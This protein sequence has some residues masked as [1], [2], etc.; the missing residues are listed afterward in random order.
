MNAINHYAAIRAAFNAFP[1]AE[2][3]E[4]RKALEAAKIIGFSESL[5]I[6]KALSVVRAFLKKL[7][8]WEREHE[9]G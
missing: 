5:Q 8:E 3:K 4:A 1:P 2:E 9:L 6:N 7:D